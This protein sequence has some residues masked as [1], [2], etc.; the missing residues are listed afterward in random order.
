MGTGD[1]NAG[2]HLAIALHPIQGVIEILLVASCHR[3]LDKLW[4]DRPLGSYGECL[5][6][7]DFLVL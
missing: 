6:L 4:P 5:I 7:C 1:L 3:N 2:D